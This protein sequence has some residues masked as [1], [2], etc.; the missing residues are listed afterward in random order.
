MFKGK[1]KQHN[2]KH[3]LLT[4]VLKF[5]DCIKFKLEFIF[6]KLHYNFQ[7]QTLDMLPVY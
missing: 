3:A 6:Y 7:F 1:I 5:V 4:T 2:G